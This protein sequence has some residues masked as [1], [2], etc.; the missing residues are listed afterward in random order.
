ARLAEIGMTVPRADR[1]AASATSM[2]CSVAYATDDSASEAKIGSARTFGR[3]VCSMR[4]D[5]WLRPRR[6]VLRIAARVRPGLRIVLDTSRDS[7]GTHPFP[8]GVGAVPTWARRGD[9][10]SVR[11]VG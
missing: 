4:H 2:I 1:L 7:R 8:D 3:S 10:R 5:G 9:A 11:W 6:M